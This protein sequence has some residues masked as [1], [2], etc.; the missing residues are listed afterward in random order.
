MPV[1]L[2]FALLTGGLLLCRARGAGRRALGNAGGAAR[3]SLLGDR[4]VRRCKRRYWR[5]IDRAP[6]PVDAR[7]RGRPAAAR[8][9]SVFER[10]HT[11]AN[12]LTREMGFVRRAQARAR[13]RAARGACCSRCCRIAVAA[14]GVA[15]RAPAT[16]APWLR[17]GGAVSA[18]AGAF[19][20]RWLF[21]A[22]AQHL[23]TLY[24]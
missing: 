17:A 4:A 3:R 19:V 6:L 13:L 18:L 20:E 5:D 2:L 23:V 21:F 16:P 8:S 22:E 12:Y 10:P 15:V 1:Y 11:E 14:A 7:R 24:Y 9:V